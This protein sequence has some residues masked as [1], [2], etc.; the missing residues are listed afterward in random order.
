MIPLLAFSVIKVAVIASAGFLTA[1]L[2]TPWLSGVLTKYRLWRKS[3]RQTA[4]GGGA[5]PVFQKF[6]QEGEVKTPRFGGV[7]IWV[8]PPALAFA[9]FLLAEASSNPWLEA[10][11]FLSRSETWLPLA[12]LAVACAVGF[13]DDILQVLPTPAGA[14][15]RSVWEKLN[16]YTAGGLSLKLRFAMISGI[17]LVGAWWFFYKLGWDSV[18]VPGIGDVYL[19]ILIIP[20]FVIVMLATYSGGV[21]DGIDGLS[22]GAFASIFTAYGLIAFSQEQIDLAAFCFAIVGALLAFLWFNV[23]PARFYMGETGI[24]GLTATLTVVAFLTDSVAVLPVIAILLVMESAS[25][26]LQLASKK[27]RGGRRVFLA[28]PIHHHFEALGWPSHTVTMRF[29]II[30]VVAAFVGVAIRLLG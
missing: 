29:W 25:V 18:F 6:H 26:I 3:V 14:F 21:I 4:L 12:T 20:L 11:N 23:P 27:L 30:G 24:M 15:W 16:R 13:L 5:V 8:T 1:F 9:L 19:G 2:L 17:G 7:L 22:G 28:A 10:F